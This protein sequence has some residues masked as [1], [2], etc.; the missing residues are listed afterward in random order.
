MLGK[1]K[2]KSREDEIW[3]KAGRNEELTPEEFDIYVQE[4]ERR[5]K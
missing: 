5:T 1:K 2:E 4:V 3:A